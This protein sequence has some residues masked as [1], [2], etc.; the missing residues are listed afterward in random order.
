MRHLS[1]LFLGGNVLSNKLYDA[2]VNA[3]ALNVFKYINFFFTNL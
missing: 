1:P 3:K 2:Q